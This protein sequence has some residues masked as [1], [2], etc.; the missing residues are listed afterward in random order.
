MTTPTDALAAALHNEAIGCRWTDAQE[1]NACEGPEHHVND[2]GLLLRCITNPDFGPN[3][4]ARRALAAALLTEEDVARAVHSLH[5]ATQEQPC[6]SCN[7]WAHAIL[8][9]LREAQS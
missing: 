3:P 8:A 7:R 5:E 4:A 9:A 1:Y 2:S 6:A